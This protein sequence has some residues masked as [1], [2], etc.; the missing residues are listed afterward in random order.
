MIKQSILE[1]LQ[2]K[3]DRHLAAMHSF[4]LINSQ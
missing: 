3:H 4:R 1:L 2:K